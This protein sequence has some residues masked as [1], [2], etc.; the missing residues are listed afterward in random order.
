MVVTALL[1]GGAS[2]GIARLASRPGIGRL[3]KRG[4]E[5]TVA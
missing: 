5:E 4:F 1:G 2:T 3:A